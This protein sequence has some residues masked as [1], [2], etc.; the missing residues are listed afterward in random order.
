MSDDVWKAQAA[1]FLRVFLPI[2]D[3][4]AHHGGAS[5]PEDV[6]PE[7]FRLDNLHA[8]VTERRYLGNQV[9][10]LPEHL[11][12]SLAL[13]LDELPHYAPDPQPGDERFHRAA[14]QHGFII[15]KLPHPLAVGAR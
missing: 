13:Y 9:P 6:V 10:T 2:R 8:V 7:E 12:Q 1:A 4:V 15:E 5:L 11:L 3:W 14:S